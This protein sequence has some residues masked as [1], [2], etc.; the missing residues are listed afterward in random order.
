M[1]DATL[2]SKTNPMTLGSLVSPTPMVASLDGET[3]NHRSISYRFLWGRLL[4]RLFGICLAF[5]FS[6]RNIYVS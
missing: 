4:F 6:E 5:I 3:S 2:G 1:G